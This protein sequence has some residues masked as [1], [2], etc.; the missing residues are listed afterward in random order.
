MQKVPQLRE[1]QINKVA[2]NTFK[3]QERDYQIRIIEDEKTKTKILI[4][5]MYGG[6]LDLENLSGESIEIFTRIVM[7]QAQFK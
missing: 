3:I 4:I 1:L 5:N 7:K 6:I 2:K